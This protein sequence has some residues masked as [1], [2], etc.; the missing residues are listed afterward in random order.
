[1][2]WYVEKIKKLSFG[3]ILD[4][5][6]KPQM[7]PVFLTISA[8]LSPLESAC[9]LLS[10][11][12]LSRLKS[13]REV[14]QSNNDYLSELN[15]NMQR[16]RC[17]NVR[18]DPWHEFLYII[19]R[20]TCPEMVM[21][22]GVFDGLSSA[23]ILQAMKD[24]NRGLLVSIDL[25][26]RKEIKGSTHCMPESK[27]PRALD[28]GWIVPNSLRSRYKLYLGDSKKLLPELFQKYPVVDIFIHDSLHTYEHQLFEYNTAWPHIKEGGLLLSDDILWTPAFYRFCRKQ[29]KQYVHIV[30]GRGATVK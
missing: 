11:E 5:L 1:M 4:R 26:A 6:S 25:P 12:K 9:M 22:T 13:W 28:P 21:E 19:V 17:R 27:L 30:G 8:P 10:N 18:V 23:V 14:Y 7:F 15:R 16:V 29:Q 20:E 24:N 2:P 3:K